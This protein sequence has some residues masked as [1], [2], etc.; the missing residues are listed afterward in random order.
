MSEIPSANPPADAG[1][2]A[3]PTV[4]GVI[5]G[6]A[7]AEPILKLMSS[8]WASAV[9]GLHF[10]R[11][12]APQDVEA[13][14]EHKSLG[15]GQM[16]IVISNLD[17]MSALE[18]GQAF[19]SYYSGLDI[20]YVAT[21]I[22]DLDLVMMR[23]NGYREVFMMPHDQAFMLEELQEFRSKVLGKPRP[24]KS[25]QI[26]DIQ[27]GTEL[28]FEVMT[29]LPLNKKY[30]RAN[31][32]GAIS[33]AKM[34][35]LQQRGVNQ[36]FIDKKDADK[37]YQYSAAQLAQTLGGGQQMSE[38]AKKEKAQT[39]IRGLFRGVVSKNQGEASFSEGRDL[40]EQS[41]KVIQG[42]VTARTGVDLGSQLRQVIGQ[43]SDSFSHAHTVSTLCA[44]FSM[45]TGIG[46]PEDLAIAGLFHDLGSEVAD[47]E[48]V[49]YDLSR[50][51]PAER[52]KYVQHGKT[53]V[54]LL[55]DKKVTL[56]PNVVEI[57]E[58]HHE[59]AD[60]KG[61]PDQLPGHKVPFEAQLL[62]YA[63]QFEV[64]SRRVPGRSYRTPLQ[65]HEIIA[66]NSGIS[67]EVLSKVR[68]FLKAAE[69]PQVAAG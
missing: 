48:S 55:K 3:A 47:D 36:L 13:F 46:K 22:E 14:L 61:F 8:T 38:T 19:S 44:L 26:L 20:V 67:P 9:E 6:A 10:D 49:L 18:V 11:I 69:A 53:S 42:M 17:G 30:V 54:R 24:Y 12:Q 68:G 50:L 40:L 28:P 63:D 60:G 45:A 43:D 2:V 37:F 56:M 25:V 51:S 21:E 59:R 39:L 27:S 32:T 57:I 58:R 15:P 7:K 5:V 4:H 23:K 33:E 62:A 66:K 31:A 29:Y 16:A 64:L 1:A 65:I 41:Q 52:E 35:A 34:K